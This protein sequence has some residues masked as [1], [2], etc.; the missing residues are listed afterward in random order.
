M[1]IHPA[2]YESVHFPHI[3]YTTNLYQFYQHKKKKGY[4]ILFFVCLIISEAKRV[5]FIYWPIVCF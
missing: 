4:L 5:L 2:V 1:V 3:L